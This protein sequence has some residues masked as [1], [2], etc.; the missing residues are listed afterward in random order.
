M[1]RIGKPGTITPAQ[2]QRL[3]A[4]HFEPSLEWSRE[5]ADLI[6]D[7][8]VYLRAAIEAV[9][10]DR[11]PPEALQ[12]EVLTFIL[13]DE[14]LRLHVLQWGN[15]RRKA[16]VNRREALPRDAHFARVAAFIGKACAAPDRGR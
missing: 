13:S 11:Q 4:F 10:N 2:L 8:V 3:Q 15:E 5:E 16:P 9:T 12:N 7:A 14:A 6:L 1:P